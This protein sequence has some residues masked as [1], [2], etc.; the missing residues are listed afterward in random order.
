MLAFP[1]DQEGPPMPH[2]ELEHDTWRT[3]H[4]THPDTVARVLRLPHQEVVDVMSGRIY[5]DGRFVAAALNGVPAEFGDLFRVCVPN[6]A[7]V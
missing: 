6:P 5:P 1:T 3:L 4:L 7:V 2:L